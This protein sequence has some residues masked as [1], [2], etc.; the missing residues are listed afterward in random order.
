MSQQAPT[1]RRRM[2]WARGSVSRRS[3]LVAGGLGIS[4]GLL[5]CSAP[6]IPGFTSDPDEEPK[7][8]T[9]AS[10]QEL[11]ALYSAV[12]AAI[13]NLAGALDPIRTQHTQHLSA[14]AADLAQAPEPA[15]APTVP[16]NR[17]AALNL[18]RKAERTAARLRTETAVVAEDTEVIELLVRIG[19]SEAS[20][21]AYLQKINA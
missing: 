7:L 1:P 3:V 14:I 4:A 12:I 10:E 16:A 8:L 5:G 13:P 19:A 20:H 6:S 21:N 9:V 18:L 2:P 11:I 15:P 17:A